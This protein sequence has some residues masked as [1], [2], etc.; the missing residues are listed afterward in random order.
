[1]FFLVNWAFGLFAQQRF[2]VVERA[3]SLQFRVVERLGKLA[4]EPIGESFAGFGNI[5]LDLDDADLKIEYYARNSA[6]LFPSFNLFSKPAD[7]FVIQFRAANGVLQTIPSHEIV[8]GHFGRSL[9]E[10]M[11]LDWT[12]KHLELGE[13][14]TIII[15]KKEWIDVDCSQPRPKFSKSTKFTFG[16]YAVAGLGGVSYGLYALQKKKSYLK[17]YRAAWENGENLSGQTAEA[18]KKAEKWKTR[19]QIWAYSGLGVLYLDWMS[20]LLSFSTLKKRKRNYDRYCLQPATTQ[21]QKMKPPK[22]S[23]GQVEDATLGMKLT[24]NF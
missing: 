12:E 4:V 20:A 16:L 13:I 24:F 6:S 14:F 15:Q 19:S 9:K 7:Q 21:T 10:F 1:M 17:K 11:W 5:Q 18:L 3:D 22:L 23:I 8:E 2:T